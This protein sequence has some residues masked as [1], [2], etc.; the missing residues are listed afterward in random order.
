MADQPPATTKNDTKDEAGKTNGSHN[1]K[2]PEDLNKKRQLG[3]F[4]KFYFIKN[5]LSLKS[6]RN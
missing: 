1:S 4:K 3:S 5:K 2:F 6:K